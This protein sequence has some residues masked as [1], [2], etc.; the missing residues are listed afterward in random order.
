MVCDGSRL[1]PGGQQEGVG[2]VE[3]L[4]EMAEGERPDVEGERGEVALAGA[5]SEAR[6]RS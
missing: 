6:S 3:E 4:G 2:D 5:T 1:G